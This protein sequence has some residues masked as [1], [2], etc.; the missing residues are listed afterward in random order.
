LTSLR[1][2]ERDYLAADLATVETMIARLTD[3]DVV[4]RMGLEER[5]DE[6]RRELASLPATSGA[7]ASAGLFF[8]GRPVVGGQGIESQFGGRA[9]AAFQDLVANEYAHEAGALGQRGVVP[10]KAATTLHI[11]NVLRGSFGFLLEEMDAAPRL[12]DT[13]LKTA[14]D[15][16]SRLLAAF[17]EEDE[18]RF[19][20]AVESVDERVLAKARDFLSM[21]RQDGATFRLVAGD[22]DRSFDMVSVERGAERGRLTTIDDTEERIIGVLAG[23]LPQGHMFEFRTDADGSIIRGKVDPALSAPDLMTMSRQW[24][25]EPALAIIKARRVLKAGETVRTGYTLVGLERAPIAVS[26][27]AGQAEI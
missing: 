20:A 24:L 1:K 19:A 7:M 23:L 15:N 9:V 12:F 17:G 8:A 4:M 10:N 2:L 26:S 22:S 21:M 14:V 25:F 6:L 3:E 16:V 27:T 11:T 13:T 5:R 18:E